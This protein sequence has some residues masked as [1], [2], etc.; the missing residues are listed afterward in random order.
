MGKMTIDNVGTTNGPIGPLRYTVQAGRSGR[1]RMRERLLRRLHE[2]FPQTEVR[3]EITPWTHQINRVLKQAYDV[4][5]SKS[6]KPKH[7]F[8]PKRL[9]SLGMGCGEASIDR[10]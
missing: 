9:V 8:Q 10:F 7:R 4:G 1:E 3:K 2:D 5:P 6:F